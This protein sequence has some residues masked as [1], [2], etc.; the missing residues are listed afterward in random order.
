MSSV[1]AI[2]RDFMRDL[3]DKV[4]QR[5]Y[6]VN[7]ET[8]EVETLPEDQLPDYVEHSSE[9]NRIGQLTAEAIVKDYEATAKM[10]DLMGQELIKAAKRCDEEKANLLETAIVVRQVAQ[11]CRDKGKETFER[12]EARSA[13]TEKIRRV[14]GEMMRQF[15]DGQT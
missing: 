3:E 14:A 8:R 10:I 7:T 6:V 12:I 15:D 4:V 13:I 2:S 1:P 11:R 9:A 5:P